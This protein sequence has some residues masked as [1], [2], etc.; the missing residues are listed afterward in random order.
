MSGRCVPARLR[1]TALTHRTLEVRATALEVL[2]TPR[3]PMPI[4]VTK[5]RMQ[6]GGSGG[7]RS[8]AGIADCVS[9]TV[10]AE[11]VRALWRGLEPA[12]WRQCFYGGA[13]YGLYG[14][15]KDFLAPGV[16]KAELP[17]STKILAGGLRCARRFPLISTSTCSHYP[18]SLRALG[19]GSSAKPFWSASIHLY[20]L[21]L[22][23]L[24][25][26]PARPS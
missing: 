25:S 5:T 20:S 11:G 15:I 6:L 4:D 19:S 2:S 24:T 26:W 10:R 3:Q 16:P 13:R 18:S 23:G 9:S 1:E 8:Y 12:L 17:L 14:P 21:F 7:V 22:G